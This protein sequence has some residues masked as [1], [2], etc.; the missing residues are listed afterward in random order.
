MLNFLQ[1]NK[2][3]IYTNLIKMFNV[4]CVSNIFADT[5]NKFNHLSPYVVNM[6]IFASC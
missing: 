4:K 5:V 3:P 6:D 2:I 1:Q